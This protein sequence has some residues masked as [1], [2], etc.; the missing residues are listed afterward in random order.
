MQRFPVATR[1]L[2]SSEPWLHLW[3]LFEMSLS[4]MDFHLEMSAFAAVLP[5]EAQM[6]GLAILEN[7][8][9]EP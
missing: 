8:H 7:S 1:S 5:A 2:P 4:T 6:A 3:M 9:S